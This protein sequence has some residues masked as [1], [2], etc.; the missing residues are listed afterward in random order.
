MES[1]TGVGRAIGCMGQAKM[2]ALWLVCA[3]L[4][5]CGYATGHGDCDLIRQVTVPGLEK[6]MYVVSPVTVEVSGRPG[7]L[8]SPYT[9]RVSRNVLYLA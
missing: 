5:L 2:A 8:P 3:G 6:R 1:L 9:L 4:L 7:G